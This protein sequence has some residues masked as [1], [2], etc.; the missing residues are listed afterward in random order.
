LERIERL[1]LLSSS[2]NQI[3]IPPQVQDEFGIAL[4]WLHI[5]EVRDK[6]LLLALRVGLDEGEAAAIALAM[7]YPEAILILDDLKART[8]AQQM[9]LKIMGTIGLILR[10][11]RTGIISEVQPVLNQLQSVG[12]YI[13]DSLFQKALILA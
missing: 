12:F 6:N 2:F 4:N 13:T 7:E 5:Q 11:K 9:G 10:C 3:L 1:D 8:I